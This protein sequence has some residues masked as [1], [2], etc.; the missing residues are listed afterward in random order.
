MTTE[1]TPAKAKRIVRYYDSHEREEDT[2]TKRSP[3][4][5]AQI[6]RYYDTHQR[7]GE[8]L[9]QNLFHFLVIEYLLGV[10]KWLYAGQEVG[11]A[12]NVSF[13]HTESSDEPGISP[14]IAIVD[15]LVINGLPNEQLPSYHIGVNGPAPRVVIEVSSPST[16]RI[17]LEN[18]P[19]RYQELGVA[20][21]FAFDP[22][23]PPLWRDRW[24]THQRLLGWRRN[25][26]GQMVEIQKR[27]DGALWSE[28]LNSWLVLLEGD[29]FLRL[30]TPEGVLRIDQVKFEQLQKQI[31][32]EQ[33]EAEKQQRE[34]LERENARLLEE[35]RRLKGE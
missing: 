24:L 4:K 3:I 15:E 35:L 34:A 19:G 10:L 21:Y 5:P 32:E 22:G 25:A 30:Y 26:A 23:R 16:W 18:K 9:S 17:D 31:A 1:S 29:S 14:D 33:A 12:S 11:F 8:E 2:A 28:Q 13:Y 20:E 6:V 27:G 7:E